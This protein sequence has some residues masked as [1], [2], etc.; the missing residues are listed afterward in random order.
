MEIDN[1]KFY[2]LPTGSSSP[3]PNRG[4]IHC[5][6]SNPLKVSICRTMLQIAI[7]ET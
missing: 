5:W 1:N 6:I 2:Q 4:N 3:L 7:A